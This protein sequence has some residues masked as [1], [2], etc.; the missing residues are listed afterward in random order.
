MRT[1]WSK[2][3]MDLATFQHTGM[4]PPIR[5]KRGRPPK[6]KSQPE[7]RTV[8][9]TNAEWQALKNQIAKAEQNFRSKKAAMQVA[10]IGLQELKHRLNKLEEQLNA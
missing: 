3:A 2:R 5:R 7:S 1:V 8:I 6:A 4:P 9:K 10:G